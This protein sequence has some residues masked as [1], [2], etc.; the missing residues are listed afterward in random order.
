MKFKLIPPGRFMMGSP[1]SELGFDDKHQAD[2]F[3]H[4]VEITKPF[5]VGVYEVTQGQYQR[6]MGSNPAY[7]AASGEGKERVSGLTT[8]GFPVENV[9]WDD[10]N[11]FI[12]KLNVQERS[13]GRTYRL[14]TEAEWE[15]A[16]RAG[17]TT[18]FSFGL[19]FNGTQANCDGKYP[20]GTQTKGKYLERPETVGRYPSNPFGLFDMHGNV[21]EW[22]E[23]LY[24]K[25]FYQHSQRANPVNLE[26]G[27]SRV[28]RGGSWIYS[29]SDCRSAVRFNFDP[30]NRYDHIGF[31]VVLSVE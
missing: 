9:S 22:C 30:A 11:A 4:P 25:E 24:D 8:T 16:C 28:L 13:S 23:D 10:V 17:T 15:F 3:H 31:R 21:W 12:E 20:Y 6:I 27:S 7:F 18:P 19:Q 1:E 14:P 29:A 5:Y 26:S 2:E